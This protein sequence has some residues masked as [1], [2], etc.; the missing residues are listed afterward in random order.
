MENGQRAQAALRKIIADYKGR[1]LNE[2]D[3]SGL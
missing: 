1:G 2:A 3:T